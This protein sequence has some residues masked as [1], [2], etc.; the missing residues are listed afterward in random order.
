[1]VI[2]GASCHGLLPADRAAVILTATV[3]EGLTAS[4]LAPGADRN[5]LAGSVA[6]VL[7]VRTVMLCGDCRI[8]WDPD[9]QPLCSDANHTHRE[10]EVHRHQ[11]EVQLPDGTAVTAVSFHQAAPYEREIIPDFGL[12]LDPRWDP[13]WS[14]SVVDWPDFGVPADDAALRLGLVDLLERARRG[15]RVEMGCLGAHGRTGTALACL[16]AMAGIESERAVE[17]VRANYCPKA[18]ETA[19]QEAFV[20]SYGAGS[21]GV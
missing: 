18:V 19:E 7:E 21:A 4:R 5:G 20:S 9:D 10:W 15:Q 6:S 17:W 2:T 16:A 8:S 14:H 11:T 13:P 3:T 1:V 12:Y